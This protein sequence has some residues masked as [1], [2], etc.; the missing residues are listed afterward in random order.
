MTSFAGSS[1]RV[2]SREQLAEE[3]R[4]LLAGEIATVG[5]DFGTSRTGFAYQFA[6]DGDKEADIGVS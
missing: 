3:G 1:L 2:R 5:I 6:S 4:R